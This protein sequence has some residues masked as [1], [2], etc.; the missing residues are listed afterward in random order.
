MNVA[1]WILLGILSACFLSVGIMVLILDRNKFMY[2]MGVRADWGDAVSDR[3][4]KLSGIFEILG[5]LGLILPTVTSTAKSMTDLA[6]VG[7]IVLMSIAIGVHVG[8]QDRGKSVSKPIALTVGL[9][10]LLVMRPR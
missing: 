2:T 1:I 10:L 9:V 5:A 6:A 4:Y 7:L 3:L 8:I